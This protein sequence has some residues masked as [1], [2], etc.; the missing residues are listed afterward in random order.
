MAQNYFSGSGIPVH[1]TELFL[2]FFLYFWNFF[3]KKTKKRFLM[4]R[5]IFE[6]NDLLRM[7]TLRATD[8]NA[9]LFVTEIHFV[10]RAPRTFFLVKRLFLFDY[11]IKGKC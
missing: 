1:F 9:S 5:S 8:L 10:F 11:I 3:Q 6:L 7:Q 4:Y 2:C